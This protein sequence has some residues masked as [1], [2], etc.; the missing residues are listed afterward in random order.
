MKWL[1]NTLKHVGR[2]RTKWMKYT[3]KLSIV[4]KRYNIITIRS[5]N[6]IELSIIFPFVFWFNAYLINA[7]ITLIVQL[8]HQTWVT[9]SPAKKPILLPIC[10]KLLPPFVTIMFSRTWLT[11][12]DSSSTPPLFFSPC[13]PLNEGGNCLIWSKRYTFAFQQT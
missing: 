8:M 7:G 6:I 10:F 4:I 12:M 11:F 2:F 9:H 1:H 13:N 5:S 3:K